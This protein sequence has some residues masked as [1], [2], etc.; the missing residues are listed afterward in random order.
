[1]KQLLIII[2]FVA[3]PLTARANTALQPLVLRE[4]ITLALDHNALVK[5]AGHGAQAAR[6]GVKVVAS[7][8]Y[9][10][11]AFEEVF[12]AS[13]SPTQTFMMKL[14]QGRFTNN[15]FLI[16]NLNNPSDWHD[17]R[18]QLSV[19]QPLYVPSIGTATEIARQE[20]D[21]AD[22]RHEGTRQEI[23]FQVFR[24]FLQIKTGKARL[25]AAQQSLG[26]SRENLRLAAVRTA[27]GLGLRSDE[28][29]AR[30]YHSQ[31]E[32]N[33]LA[34]GNDLA[35]AKRQLCVTMGI[36][37]NDTLD[38]VDPAPLSPPD[39]GEEQWS[40]AKEGRMDLQSARSELARAEAGVKL[41]RSAYFP[42]LGGFASYQLND[43]NVPFSS[44]N[45]AWVAGVS[46]KWE[47]FDGFRRYR[48]SDQAR[49]NRAAAQEVLEN[50]GR[51]I[52][53]Q[54]Y[55]AQVRY[56]EA[57]QRR[58]VASNALA[59]AE[60]TVRLLTRRYENSLSTMVEL[61]DAQT[62]LNQAR[63]SVVEA[64]SSHSLAAGR[65]LHTT[66]TFLKEMLK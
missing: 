23:A 4:A 28:L 29:R 6:H 34:A 30:T 42:S 60:E 3:L 22:Y 50:T 18:T 16:Q 47:L 17:F 44:D 49:A 9:P 15:D 24:S 32:Q 1:M 56:R 61:L 57:A 7:R 43:R 52:E 26:E 55:E 39:V 66:G 38:I 40:A 37:A 51:E 10:T 2:L 12:T 13:N 62:A 14:D 35:L 48:A 20:A 53:Y 59:D 31:M 41:S 36:P 5:A 64:E 54:I 25:N 19:Q 11:V 8:Y 33:V 65:V 46:L 45:D 63:A 21:Q 27:A 58:T